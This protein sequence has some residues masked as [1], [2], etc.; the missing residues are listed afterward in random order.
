MRVGGVE[1]T[2][3]CYLSVGGGEEVER[4]EVSTPAGCWENEGGCGGL[5]ARSVGSGEVLNKMAFVGSGAMRKEAAHQRRSRAG[6]ESHDGE[7]C[8]ARAGKLS[9]VVALPSWAS[10]WNGTSA[11]NHHS[12]AKYRKI[13]T[14][15]KKSK[16]GTVK[17]VIWYDGNCENVT[18]R[19]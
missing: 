9:R 15:K 14:K 5:I 16:P 6:C 8:D 17:V 3:G 13:A 1:P 2:S 12:I 19:N 18:G 11:Q 4:G 10:S 7:G